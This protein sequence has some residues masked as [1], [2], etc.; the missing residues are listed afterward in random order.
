L[1]TGSWTAAEDLLQEAMSRTFR[2]LP[3][4]P[5]DSSRDAYLMKAMTRLHVRRTR[6]L[7]N[8]EVPSVPVDILSHDRQSDGDLDVRKAL[9]TLPAGQRLVLVYRYFLDMSVAD[10]AIAMNCKEGTV[11]S[12]TSSG[13]AALRRSLVILDQR[14]AER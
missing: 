6:R 12:Q 13:L 4:L 7:W 5:S 11:K 8:R 3:A 14:K 10:T 1:L 9:L 2:Q